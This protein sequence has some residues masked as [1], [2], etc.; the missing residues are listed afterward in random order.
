MEKKELGDSMPTLSGAYPSEGG[1]LA[2]ASTRGED[3][4]YC[5]IKCHGGTRGRCHHMEPTFCF[6]IHCC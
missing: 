2:E 6:S 4:D 5:Q 3:R 1:C